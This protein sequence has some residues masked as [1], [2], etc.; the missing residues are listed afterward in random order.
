M[1]KTTSTA[2]QVNVKFPSAFLVEHLHTTIDIVTQI[3]SKSHRI[4]NNA[5]I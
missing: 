4:P 2:L 5:S 3:I 1:Y